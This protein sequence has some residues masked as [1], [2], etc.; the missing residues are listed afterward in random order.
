MHNNELKLPQKVEFCKICV[1][2]NQRPNSIIEFKNS[3]TDKETIL[4]DYNKDLNE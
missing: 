4:F 3:N 1:I 2:S